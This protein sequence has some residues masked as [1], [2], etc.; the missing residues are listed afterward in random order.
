MADDETVDVVD[1]LTVIVGLV[2]VLLLLLLVVLLLLLA[3][4]ISNLFD[5]PHVSKVL[6]LQGMLQPTSPLG[7]GPPPE[8][9]VLSHQHSCPYSTP[10]R[11]YPAA[12]HAATHNSIVIAGAP[13]GTVSPFRKV[14]PPFTPSV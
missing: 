10:A 2:L 6:P 5:P 7:A 3:M 11:L 13:P 14:R 8:L 4:N 1:V 9:S 12:L